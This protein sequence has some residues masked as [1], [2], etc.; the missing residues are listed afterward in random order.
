[1]AATGARVTIFSPAAP[2]FKDAEWSLTM[3]GSTWEKLKLLYNHGSLKLYSE[4]AQL[5]EEKTRSRKAHVRRSY[6]GAPP[7]PVRAVAAFNVISGPAVPG[8]VLAGDPIVFRYMPGYLDMPAAGVLRPKLEEM[9]ATLVGDF[10]RFYFEMS[11]LSRAAHIVLS[12]NGRARWMPRA[13][14]PLP[15]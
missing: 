8:L 10:S 3:R 4:F 9:Q 7:R 11:A 1:M 12:P 6:I 2:F 5:N 14:V 13:I 15:G